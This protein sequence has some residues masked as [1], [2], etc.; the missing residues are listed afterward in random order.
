MN[1]WKTLLEGVI[2]VLLTTACAKNN[3]H[4]KTGAQGHD[5][6]SIITPA[7]CTV[8]SIND[9]VQAVTRF[10]FT[11]GTTNNVEIQYLQINATNPPV[12][13]PVD[14]VYEWDLPKI[15]AP[16]Y[17]RYTVQFLGNPQQLSDPSEVKEL[18]EQKKLFE[19]KLRDNPQLKPM[20]DTFNPQQALSLQYLKPVSNAK[21][22]QVL[23]PCTDY[24]NAFL[25]TEPVRPIMEFNLFIGQSQRLRLKDLSQQSLGKTMTFTFPMVQLKTMATAK[26]GTSW[27]AWREEEFQRFIVDVVTIGNGIFIKTELTDY[28]FSDKY[29]TYFFQ[30]IN[31]SDLYSITENQEYLRGTTPLDS[32]DSK[33]GGTYRSMFAAMK[34]SKGLVVLV[35]MNPYHP[36]STSVRKFADIYFP[37]NDPRPLAAHPNVARN[38]PK[39]I[40]QQKA[41][42][43]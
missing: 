38:L 7:W 25:V 18:N 42:L 23:F 37:C 35:K 22:E 8:E 15:D 4:S 28:L 3:R 9:T 31:E 19:K 14:T 17:E 30:R 11:V 40:E 43:R 20:G 16:D 10:K 39:A 13:Y 36:S 1:L 21:V 41:K 29:S 24:S 27:C 2:I 34:D 26:K 6:E 32:G 5:L 33:P 12:V